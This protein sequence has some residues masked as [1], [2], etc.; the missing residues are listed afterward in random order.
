MNNQWTLHQPIFNHKKKNPHIYL[1]LKK[2]LN[3][4]HLSCVFFWLGCWDETQLSW[5]TEAG[6]TVTHTCWEFVAP[7]WPVWCCTW[8]PVGYPAHPVGCRTGSAW[9]CSPRHPPQLDSSEQ[10]E[11]DHGVWKPSCTSIGQNKKMKVY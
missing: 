2:M 1:L 5:D 6:P 8:I 3:H 11:R 7:F 9:T 10:L 4:S